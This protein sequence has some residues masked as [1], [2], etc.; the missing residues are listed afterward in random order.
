MNALRAFLVLLLPLHLFAQQ[1]NWTVDTTVIRFGEPITVTFS[2]TIHEDSAVVFP[3][4]DV[5]TDRSFVIIN[6]DS[7]VNK[8]K[9]K[10]KAIQ[11]TVVVTSFDTGFAVLEPITWQYNNNVFESEPEMIEVRWVMI[12]EGSSLFDIKD[13]LSV[14]YPWYVYVL[15]IVIIILLVLMTRYIIRRVKR[16]TL[17]PIVE[18]EAK[19][20]DLAIERINVLRSSDLWENEKYGLF[21]LE[22]TTILRQY[23]ERAHGVR[24][25]EATLDELLKQLHL[26][27]VTPEQNVRMS[28][29]FQHADLVKYAKQ[30]PN[31]P[32]AN[33]YI[34]EAV[35]FVNWLNEAQNKSADV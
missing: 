4:Y 25:M 11:Q 35:T 16:P 27:P 9:Q 21:F 28:D 7:L 8:P 10:Q 18:P 6:K 33:D 14:P 26:L 34:D 17:E 13:V 23:F 30:A 29:F 31:L 32:N 24:A 5:W 3:N 20:Y 12:E 15:I 19:P 22:L 2:A 1:P